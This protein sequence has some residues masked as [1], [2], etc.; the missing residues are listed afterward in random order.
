MPSQVMVDKIQSIPREKIGQTIGRLDDSA[1]L[2]VNRALAVF[3][4]FA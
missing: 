2:A 4:G 1:L 3:L